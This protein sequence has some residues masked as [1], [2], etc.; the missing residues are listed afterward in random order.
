M[1]KIR[2]KN[3]AKV[4]GL[5]ALMAVTGCAPVYQRNPRLLKTPQDQ[6]VVKGSSPV[7]DIF[8]VLFS[9]LGAKPSQSPTNFNWQAYQRNFHNL[10]PQ[11]N[12]FDFN[13]AFYCFGGWDLNNN[14]QIFRMTDNIALN[15]EH[16]DYQVFNFEDWRDSLE[17]IK[18]QYFKQS[19]IILIGHSGGGSNA[20]KATKVLEKVNVPVGLMLVDSTHLKSEEYFPPIVDGLFNNFTIPSNV[21]HVENYVTDGPYEGRKLRKSD[22]ANFKTTFRNHHLR[23]HHLT[24]LENRF[25]PQYI[26]SINQILNKR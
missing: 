15:I 3:K 13:P 17:K 14:N 2:F 9:A 10:Q 24:P 12:N 25:A 6:K 22:F 20:I 23:G 16:S 19:P 1:E 8:I 11:I 7:E 4:M 26:R 5:V 21:I 18:H